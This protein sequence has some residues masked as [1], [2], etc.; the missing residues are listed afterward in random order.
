MQTNVSPHHMEFSGVFLK[1]IN[2]YIVTELLVFT[3]MQLSTQKK[4]RL[5]KKQQKQLFANVLEIGVL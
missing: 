5:E 1:L 2:I 4:V 3:A